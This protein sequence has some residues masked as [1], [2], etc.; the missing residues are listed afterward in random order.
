[1]KHTCKSNSEKCLKMEDNDIRLH[2]S[3]SSSGIVRDGLIGDYPTR[4]S[5]NTGPTN[6]RQLAVL[7]QNGVA[8]KDRKGAA[9]VGRVGESEG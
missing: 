3:L 8:A 1:M 4:Q 5:K 6:N 7:V 2:A 9:V